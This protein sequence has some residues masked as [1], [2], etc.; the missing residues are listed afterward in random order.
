MLI[1]F[2]LSTKML[3]TCSRVVHLC[4]SFKFAVH[5]LNVLWIYGENIYSS[6][7]S[8]LKWQHFTLV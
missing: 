4:A 6:K 2:S 7:L 8:E 5:W 1:L 3:L